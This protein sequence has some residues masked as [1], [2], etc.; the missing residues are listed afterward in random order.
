MPSRRQNAIDLVRRNG[1]AQ[2][3][4]L[5]LVAPKFAEQDSLFFG[6]DTFGDDPATERMAHADDRPDDFL[7][8]GIGD[9][10]IDEAA[11]DF[12]RMNR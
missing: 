3:V 10:V 8:I 5:H 11:I 7:V 4:A 2:E 6:F 1:G 12:N 9:D